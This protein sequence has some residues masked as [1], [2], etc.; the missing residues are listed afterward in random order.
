MAGKTMVISLP[1]DVVKKYGLKKSQE[2]E[3]TEDNGKISILIENQLYKE[4]CELKAKECLVQEQLESLY[5]QGYNE[6]KVFYENK[7]TL[8]K[9]IKNINKKFIGFQVLDS[10]SKYCII[11]S[12]A[13]ED[14]TKLQSLI[15]R[16][17]LILLSLL[18]NDDEDSRENLIKLINVCK[19]MLHQRNY[20]F[21]EAMLLYNL[22][23]LIEEIS[24]LE[25]KNKKPAKELIEPIYNLYYKFDELKY[26]EIKGKIIEEFYKSKKDS[27]K[28][29]FLYN[30]EK[31]LDLAMMMNIRLKK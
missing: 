19:R 27:D 26:T 10:N 5:T 15:R 13:K 2:L 1:S 24:K 28:I 20:N 4:P 8:K 17:F 29:L 16:S 18:E 25:Y 11:K 30:V 21:N 31:M 6:I 3:V 9:I 12:I 22:T 14:D 7:T 23:V